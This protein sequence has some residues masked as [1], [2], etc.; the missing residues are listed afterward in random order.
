[1]NSVLCGSVHLPRWATC[2]VLKGVHSHAEDTFTDYSENQGPG[3]GEEWV[4]RSQPCEKVWAYRLRKWVS[5]CESIFTG[6]CKEKF[7]QSQ[8][9][10]PKLSETK[11][12][13]VWEGYD[14]YLSHLSICLS[15]AKSPLSRAGQVPLGFCSFSLYWSSHGRFTCLPS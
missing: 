9:P 11:T 10:K 3:E 4:V 13:V 6:D 5:K 15:L 7:W 2:C 12:V 1:M 14:L 8:D